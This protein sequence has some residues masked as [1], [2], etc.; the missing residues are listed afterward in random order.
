MPHFW[1]LL[2][3]QLSHPYPQHIPRLKDAHV[4]QPTS[5][6]PRLSLDYLEVCF[7][8]FPFYLNTTEC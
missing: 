6:K 4:R 5:F 2:L 8:N 1:S 7:Y 3:Q